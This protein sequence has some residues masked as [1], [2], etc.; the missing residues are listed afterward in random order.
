M[1]VFTCMEQTLDCFIINVKR[2]GKNAGTEFH[3]CWAGYILSYSW[4]ERD[5]KG[6]MREKNG[7]SLHAHPEGRQKS[8]SKE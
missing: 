3:Y 2:R 8:E 4:L 7:D 5:E 1:Y 6:Q